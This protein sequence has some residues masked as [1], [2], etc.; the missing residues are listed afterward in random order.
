MDLQ[1][2]RSFQALAEELSIPAAARR[3][4]MSESGLSR[5]LQ[6]LE[7]RMGVQLFDRSQS[8]M[9]STSPTSLMTLTPAGGWLLSRVSTLIGEL[10]IAADQAHLSV[11]GGPPGPVPDMGPPDTGAPDTVSSQGVSAERVS[12]AGAV[13]AEV[14]PVR[15]AVRELGPGNLQ[16]YLSLVMPGRRVVVTAMH[17]VESLKRLDAG[18]GVDAVL[19][20]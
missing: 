4:H 19:H 14:A 1:D 20:L 11:A 2:L 18:D 17:P 10:Q 15:L 7:R 8:A 9:S 5:R 6:R 13:M 3:L 16:G 12:A